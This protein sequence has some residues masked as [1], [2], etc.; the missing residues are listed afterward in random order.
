MYEYPYIYV[1]SG[2]PIY[3]FGGAGMY[4]N[5]FLRIYKYCGYP[6]SIYAVIFRRGGSIY[7]CIYVYV[8]YTM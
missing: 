8:A 7:E 5:I 1:Y 3:L 2:Y 4:E 6:A